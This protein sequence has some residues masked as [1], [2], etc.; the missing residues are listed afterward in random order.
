M[1]KSYIESIENLKETNYP[2]WEIYANGKFAS[3]DKRVFTNWQ[4]LD[5]DINEVRIEK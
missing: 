5:F 3:L 2:M 1:P 4:K